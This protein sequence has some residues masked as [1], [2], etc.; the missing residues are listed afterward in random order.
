MFERDETAWMAVGATTRS[1]AGERLTR[2]GYA[3]V[4]APLHLE[5]S[6]GALAAGLQ[7]LVDRS[8]PAA[9]WRELGDQ[10]AR[11]GGDR[12]DV[13]WARRP[14][15]DGRGGKRHVQVP[16]GLSDLVFAD[17]RVPQPIRDTVQ[18]L[19]LFAF[20]ARR[21]LTATT[22]RHDLHYT[23]RA[24]V[25]EPD[26]G[27]PTHIDDGAFSVVF[28]DA[29]GLLRVRH[30]RDRSAGARGLQPVP[31]RDWCAVVIP[32]RQ[33]PLVLPG[34]TATPHAADAPRSGPRTSISVFA[35]LPP[36]ATMEPV[37]ERT[38]CVLGR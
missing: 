2:D 37:I 10:W 27:V 11:A 9:H 8:G 35:S 6:A 24:N 5:G 33:A 19:D 20:A 13:T 34:L 14:A 15:G 18:R 28:T 16:A 23:A 17:G 25:Y 1:T 29:P 22:G 30:G 32:G 26:G 21:L 4:V 31:G 38:G 12:R 36:A 7:A 3:R